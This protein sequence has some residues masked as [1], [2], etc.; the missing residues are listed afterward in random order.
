MG[1]QLDESAQSSPLVLLLLDGWGVASAGEANILSLVDTTNFS[2]L[3]KDYP[4][5]Q[6]TPGKKNLNC[7]YLSLGSGREIEDENDKRELSTL[8]KLLSVNNLK[9]IKI[10]ETERFAAATYYFNAWQEERIVGEEHI[11][12]SSGV[13]NPVK[14]ITKETIKAIKGREHDFILSVIADIDLVANEGNVKEL[15]TTIEMVDDSLRK[16]ANEV[17][18][19]GGTLIVSSIGGNAE[20]MYNLASDTTDNLMTNN[21]VPIIIVNEEFRNKNVGLI[22]PPDHDLSLLSPAGT[23]ADIAPTIL[24]M[25]NI[26]TPEL[27]TGKSLLR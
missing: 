19:I 4:M 16:I 20:R 5:A 12:I 10:A 17:L 24:K 25:F 13:E 9:Q 15:R 26:S 27:M 21:P 22:D 23:L 6:L 11:I 7:R 14:E 1:K 3:A 2:D 18:S 8:T